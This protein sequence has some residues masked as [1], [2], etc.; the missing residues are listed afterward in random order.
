MSVFYTFYNY[1]YHYQGQVS[2]LVGSNILGVFLATESPCTFLDV[3]AELG[4]QA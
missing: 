1:H 2:R 3:K 4:L